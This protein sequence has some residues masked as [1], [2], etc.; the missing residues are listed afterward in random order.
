MNC[1][2]TWR[3]IG[4]RFIRAQRY[5]IGTTYRIFRCVACGWMKTEGL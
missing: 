1:T 3:Q 5:D 4:Q 2:H